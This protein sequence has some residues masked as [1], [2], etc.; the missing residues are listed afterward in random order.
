[1][2][3]GGLSISPIDSS[4]HPRNTSKTGNTIIN[5][6]QAL[7]TSFEEDSSAPAFNSV[8]KE[9]TSAPPAALAKYSP[10]RGQ[11]HERDPGVDYEPI[12]NIA[13]NPIHLLT[14][15]NV[16]SEAR[17]LG[18]CPSPRRSGSS[19]PSPHHVG[20]HVRYIVFGIT[21]VLIGRSSIARL[22]IFSSS[23]RWLPRARRRYSAPCLANSLRFRSNV[24]E[25]V[26]IIIDHD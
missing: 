15:A 1:M 26:E 8:H 17:Q 25:L 19:H 22:R 2:N 18:G 7:S 16:G 13:M 23:T 4:G 9:L 5:R 14:E 11:Q 24:Q 10:P 21:L 6:S 20:E 12:A 3:V